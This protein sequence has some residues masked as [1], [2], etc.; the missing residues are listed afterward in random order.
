MKQIIINKTNNSNICRLIKDCTMIL[1]DCFIVAPHITIFSSL[2]AKKKNKKLSQLHWETGC[3]YVAPVILLCH[4]KFLTFNFRFC[5]VFI[6]CFI[7]QTTYTKIQCQFFY[8]YT[9]AKHTS[10]SILI[11]LKDL[12]FY[13][14]SMANANTSYSL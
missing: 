8:F 4:N 2:Q 3:R 7:T 11:T 9:Q 5:I 12:T 6:Y 10:L 1:Q 14:T 13:D